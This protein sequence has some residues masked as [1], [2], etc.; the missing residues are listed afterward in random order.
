MIRLCIDNL[1]FTRQESTR[2]E[3][4]ERNAILCLPKSSACREARQSSNPAGNSP[5]QKACRDSGSLGPATG[6]S[7][8]KSRR[9]VTWEPKVQAASANC[10]FRRIILVLLMAFCALF[11]R[12]LSASLPQKNGD[13]ALAGIA[14]TILFRATPEDALRLGA[15]SAAANCLAGSPGAARLGH[16]RRLQNEIRLETIETGP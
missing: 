7:S 3:W 9:E 1:G 10:S 12:L 6:S 15:A 14:N 8:G 11:T 5:P 4:L 16:I 2:K 13:S